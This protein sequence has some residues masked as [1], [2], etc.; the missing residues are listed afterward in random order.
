LTFSATS[1]VVWS[2]HWVI[3][4]WVSVAIWLNSC[5]RARSLS[6]KRLLIAHQA[7]GRLQALLLG[8][9][10]RSVGVT[11]SA[12]QAVQVEFAVG[13]V[14]LH[15]GVFG[16]ET[17]YTGKVCDAKIFLRCFKVQTINCKLLFYIIYVC[18]SAAIVIK[19]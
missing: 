16:L 3:A 17:L 5:A 7:L 4:P 6:P 13:H 9:D 11:E 10:E 19:S 1:A 12:Q 8:A 15:W 2:N 14:D 18:H